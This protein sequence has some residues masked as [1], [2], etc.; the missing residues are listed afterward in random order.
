MGIGPLIDNYKYYEGFEG[1][2]ELVLCIS[3]QQDKCIHVWCGYLDDIL[4]EPVLDGTGWKG[5]TRDY[6]QLEGAFA[7]NGKT[8]DIEPEEYLEDLLQYE[9]RSFSAYETSE[10]F[11]L[12]VAFLKYAVNEH[13][14]VSMRVS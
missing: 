5:F 2:D 14:K 8:I 9:N 6:H 10:V 3:T 11:D 1:E 12:I 13:L 4:R 7:E